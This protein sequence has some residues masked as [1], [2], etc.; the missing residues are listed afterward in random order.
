ME[1]ETVAKFEKNSREEVWIT[2]NEYQGRKIFQ[3]R[4]YFKDGEGEWRPGK[5]GIAL[6]V[7]R[8]RDLAS[9]L[10]E[11]GERLTADGLLSH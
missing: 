8:Y 5:Q 7:D 3:I 4:V 9:S 6:S 11:L 1:D 2:L 10:I